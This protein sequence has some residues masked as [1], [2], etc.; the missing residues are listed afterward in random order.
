MSTPSPFPAPRP[1]PPNLAIGT[2]KA[3]GATNIAKTTRSIRDN[4]ERA[5]PFLGITNNPNPSGT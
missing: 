3:A 4:P 5:L 1:D 2:L